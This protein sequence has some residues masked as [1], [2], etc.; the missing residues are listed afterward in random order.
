[1]ANGLTPA[2]FIKK[3]NAV[4]QTEKAVSQSHFIDLCRLLDEPTPVDVDP[5][6]EW[7]FF[8]KNA[9][10]DSGSSGWADVWKRSHFGWEYKGNHA[11]LDAAYQQLRQ[12]ALGLENPPLLIVSDMRRFRIHTNWTNSVSQ[13][14]EFSMGELVDPAKLSMLKWAFSDPER[15]RPGQTREALTRNAASTFAKLAEN[16]RNSGF[17]PQ[18]VARFVNRL[19]FC[20]FAEDMRLLPDR[21]FER[22]LEQAHHRPEQFRELASDLFAKMAFGGMVGYE[23]VARFNGGLFDDDNALPLDRPGINMVR[24][25]ARLDWSDIDPSIMGTL[26]EQGL[27]PDKEQPTEAS[28]DSPDEDSLIGVHYTDPGKIMQIIEPVIERPWLAEWAAAAER[29]DA[30]LNHTNAVE[31]L[32]RADERGE[33]SRRRQRAERMLSEFLARLRNFKVLDP[34]CGSGNFLYLALRTLKNLEHR[35]NLEAQAK[36]LGRRPPTIGPANI[37]G[38]E[39]NAYAAE[40]ARTSV[41]IGEIQW[42]RRNGFREN[43][44]PILKPLDTIECRDAVL[45]EDG[46]EPEW[47]E[48]DVVIGNPPFL[49]NRRMRRELGHDYAETLPRVYSKWV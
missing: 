32:D 31:H 3:W 30:E 36:G 43:R 39:L 27:D 22:M 12:Y 49:G 40:L 10:K 6:G 15:L 2:E 48:A 1:M 47:P 19:V 42:M 16:L 21:L 13:V 8:E 34:A 38:I 23:E 46:H 14:H 25:A 33:E 17:K 7:Y 41:W 20:M 45:T 9:S 5:D 26:F 24:E 29:I 37:K 18:D 11:N 44:D 4:T 28:P 35:V